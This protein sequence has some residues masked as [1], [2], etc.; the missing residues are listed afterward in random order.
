MDAREKRDWYAIFLGIVGHKVVKGH[1]QTWCQVRVRVPSVPVSTLR[2]S[3]AGGSSQATPRLLSVANCND[4]A[5]L[6][7]VQVNFGGCLHGD[8]VLVSVCM[9]TTCS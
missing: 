7:C 5:Q 4:G 6:C 3:A 2:D 9:A 1:R 8:Y